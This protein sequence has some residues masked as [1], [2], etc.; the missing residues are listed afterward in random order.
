MKSTI[1]LPGL[2]AKPVSLHSAMGA[3]PI[4]SDAP[5]R[6]KVCFLKKIAAIPLLVLQFF[7]RGLINIRCM[8]RGI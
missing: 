1:L 8:M 4:I 3:L 7:N 6:K 5:S 2:S